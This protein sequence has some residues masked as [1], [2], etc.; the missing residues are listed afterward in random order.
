MREVA[1]LHMAAADME[2][3]QLLVSALHQTGKFIE[4]RHKP[5]ATGRKLQCVA[6]T[7][8][9]QARRYDAQFH[10]REDRLAQNDTNVQQKAQQ[11]KNKED[12]NQ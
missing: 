12:D 4:E 3:V 5:L 8:G 6:S 7:L 1:R 11:E 10:R 2:N 9:V